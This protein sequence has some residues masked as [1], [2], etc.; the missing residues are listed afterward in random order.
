ML[1][2]DYLRYYLFRAK[3]LLGN[4]KGFMIWYLLAAIAAI[5]VFYLI[6]FIF[7]AQIKRWFVEGH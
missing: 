4:R 2:F 5:G 7:W 3:S 1:I 6:Y